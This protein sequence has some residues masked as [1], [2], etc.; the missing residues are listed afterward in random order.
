MEL[1]AQGHSQ[2]VVEEEVE[3]VVQLVQEIH[4]LLVQLKELMEE[5]VDLHQGPLIGEQ[6][7]VVE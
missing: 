1:V 7:V 6:A 5:Q 4:L 3:L 2:E